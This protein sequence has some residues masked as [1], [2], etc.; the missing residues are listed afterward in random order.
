MAKIP[1]FERKMPKN[2]GIKNL[3]YMSTFF[4]ASEKYKYDMSALMGKIRKKEILKV[5]VLPKLVIQNCI[6]RLNCALARFFSKFF[7]SFGHFRHIFCYHFCRK[8][9]V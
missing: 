8:R 3:A 9:K 1:E 4:L 7:A 2:P 5:D 6:K